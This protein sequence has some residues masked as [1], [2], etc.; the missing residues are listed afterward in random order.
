MNALLVLVASAA[1]GIEVGWEP[2]PGGGH[3]YTIQIE[4]Q[5]LE[6]LEKGEDEIFSEVPAGI[7]VRRYRILVGVGKLRRDAGPLEAEVSPQASTASPPAAAAR[8]QAPAQSPAQPPT[9]QT[10]IP[11][12]SG[13][14][15]PTNDPFGTPPSTQ[16]VEPAQP[17]GAS[18]R[19]GT[20]PAAEP[21]AKGPSEPDFGSPDLPAAAPH[22]AKPAEPSAARDPWAAQNV[23]NPKGSAESPTAGS[24]ASPSDLASKAPAKLPTDNTSSGPIQKTTFAN[25]KG[26]EGEQRDAAKPPALEGQPPNQAWLPLVTSILLLGCSIGGNLYLGWIAMDARARYRAAV[27]KLRGAPA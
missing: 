22:D 17:A 19:Y 3:E 8:S 7:D 25:S 23:P 11:A 20:P 26:T 14:M 13:S 21:A 1:L 10:E 18:D 15:A 4:P 9:A 24:E 2:L 6:V 12:A 27:A 16:P 5:L